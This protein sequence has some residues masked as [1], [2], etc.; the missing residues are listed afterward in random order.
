MQSPD[1]NA[2][3]SPTE[4]PHV[5]KGMARFHAR[6]LFGNGARVMW[7]GATG[8]YDIKIRLRGRSKAYRTIGSGRSYRDALLDAIKR[9]QPI[10]EGVAK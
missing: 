5:S 9:T 4:L 1:T 6:G 8:G 2:D 3:G 7:N 10:P